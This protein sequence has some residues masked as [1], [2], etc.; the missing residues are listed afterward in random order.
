VQARDK[1]GSLEIV[2]KV[3][4]DELVPLD[5]EDDDIAEPASG[6]LA[7]AEPVGTPDAEDLVLADIGNG[8]EEI[9]LDT[10]TGGDERADLL[11]GEFLEESEEGDRWALDNS[12]LDIEQE[13][14]LDDDEHGWT[15]DSEGMGGAFD[16]ELGLDDADD[17]LV[18]DGGLEGVDDPLLDNL[19][20]SDGDEDS[21]LSDDD[22][23]EDDE[24]DYQ[25]DLGDAVLGRE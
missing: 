10:E 6:A 19:A 17:S 12:T 15:E 18:D 7:E 20:V 3:L 14:D 22:D 5:F 4:P 13:L 1:A 25:G 11:S 21:L 8:P 2:G 16:E 9:G 23:L 24:E